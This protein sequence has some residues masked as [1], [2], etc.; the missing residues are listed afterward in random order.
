MIFVNALMS[1]MVLAHW[2]VHIF[3]A[4]ESI[5]QDPDGSFA[6]ALMSRNLSP[7]CDHESIAQD[8]DGSFANALMTRNSE[9]Q[10][11]HHFLASEIQIRRQYITF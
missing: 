8:P 3:P 10:T 11:V 4:H 6:S 7:R 1:A 5:T 2:F 9:S